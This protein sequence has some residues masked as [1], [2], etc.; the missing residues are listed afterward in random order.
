MTLIFRR[1]TAG[2]PSAK[3]RNIRG[4]IA[5]FS[6]AGLVALS[7][8]PKPQES[9]VAPVRTTVKLVCSAD[10]S[11]PGARPVSSTT[12]ANW[13]IKNGQLAYAV[14]IRG[15]PGW[16]NKHTQ[17]ET[18]HDS[19][20]R[21]IQDFDVDGFRYSIVF[22]ESSGSLWALGKN[23]NVRKANVILMDRT[24]DAGVVK[25]SELLEFCWLTPPDA[26]ADILAR[27]KVTDAF[28]RGTPDT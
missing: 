11:G 17:W 25:S 20:G 24:A 23:T 8:G 15:T 12:V 26:V 13:Y 28:V 19:V 1:D 16:Y 7:C 6:G 10:Y 3:R 22:D 2:T 21:Y 9:V 4:I 14:F 5:R 18:R 27:S